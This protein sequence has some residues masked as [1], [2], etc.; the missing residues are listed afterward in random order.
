MRWTLAAMQMCTFGEQKVLRCF[1]P[2]YSLMET[3]SMSVS[4][5][6]ASEQFLGILK[7]YS[8]AFKNLLVGADHLIVI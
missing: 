8:T 3:K 7:F 2:L 1:S 5:R 4:H 6:P